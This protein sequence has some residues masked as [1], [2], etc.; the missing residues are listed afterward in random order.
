VT[1]T[2]FAEA[3]FDEEDADSEDE[4]DHSWRLKMSEE[5]IQGLSGVSPKQ[6]V[7][8]TLWNRHVFRHGSPGS[9]GDQYTRH[10]MEM[11][12]LDS[13]AELIRLGLRLQLASF[14]RALHVHGYLDADAVLGV[15]GCLDGRRRYRD[16]KNSRKPK[17]R[18]A[19]LGAPNPHENCC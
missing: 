13:R 5:E 10:G 2:R 9:Y 19:G 14:L 18:V 11:F 7:L 1:H 6:K 15:I 4:V 17:P 16:C 12:V 8:W 3:H